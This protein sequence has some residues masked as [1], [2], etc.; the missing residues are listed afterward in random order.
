MSSTTGRRR[1]ALASVI[2][3][4]CKSLTKLPFSSVMV[5]RE[6]LGTLIPTLSP[7]LEG[8]LISVPSKR[9]SVV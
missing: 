4:R 6:P 9:G 5:V 8:R 2:T 3:I 1:V 7:P